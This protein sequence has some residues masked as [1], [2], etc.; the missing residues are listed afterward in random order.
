MKEELHLHSLFFFYR[1][2]DDQASSVIHLGYKF[3]Y[4]RSGNH[5]LYNLNKDPYETTNIINVS[6]EKYIGM[7]LKAMVEDFLSKY[8]PLSIPYPKTGPLKNKEKAT[9][10]SSL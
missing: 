5:E 8:E 9:D 4:T 3:I 6:D 2:Y 10:R 1:S 7:K